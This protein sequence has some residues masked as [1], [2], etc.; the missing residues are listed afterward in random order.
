M[1]LPR[2][3]LHIDELGTDPDGTE[4]PNLDAARGE[5]MLAAREM[6][7]EWILHGAEDIPTKILITDHEM[8]LLVVVRMVDVLPRA[9]RDFKH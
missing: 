8:R 7:A 3:F 9:L 1:V 4:L 6:L 2:F 5:A